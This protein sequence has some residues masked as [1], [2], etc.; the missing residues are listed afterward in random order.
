MT[1][2][3]SLLCTQ[4]DELLDHILETLWVAPYPT[5]TGLR[6]SLL[7]AER[8]FLCF[9]SRPCGESASLGE[10]RGNRPNTAANRYRVRRCGV[11]PEDRWPPRCGWRRV[12]DGV[13]ETETLSRIAALPSREP[14]SAFTRSVKR[15]TEAASSKGPWLLEST[16]Q[17]RAPKVSQSA[18]GQWSSGRAG[19]RLLPED[20][21]DSKALLSR[22]STGKFAVQYA[23]AYQA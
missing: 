11:C 21:A 14:F 5:C 16:G 8:T 9:N 3:V 6:T 17:S 19:A 13:E 22:P 10:R 15:V 12:G 18:G 23:L 2:P 1:V 20:P 7:S 4:S